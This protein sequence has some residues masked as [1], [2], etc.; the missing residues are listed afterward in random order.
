VKPLA[1]TDT[2][3]PTTARDAAWV[4]IGAALVASLMA[5]PVLRSPSTHVFGAEIVGRQHDPF[6]VMRAFTEPLRI[7]LYSQP[8]TD[9]PGALIARL[10]GP[11][12]AY[13]WL[14]LL[15]FPL[16]AAGAFL[17]ARHLDLSRL[18]AAFA[19]LAFA[20][21]PFHLAQAAYHPHIAQVQWMPLYLLVLWRA[22]D[23]ASPVRIAWLILGAAGVALANFYAGLMAAVLTPVAAATYWLTRVRGTPAAG[24]SLG[25]TAAALGLVAVAGVGYVWRIAPAAFADATLAFDRTQLFRY[26]AAWWS[27]IVPPVT[28]PWA[29]DFAK[30]IWSS[31][32]VREGLL[33]QQVTLGAGVVLLGAAGIGA[34]FLTRRRARAL[35]AVPTVAAVAVAAFLCSLPPEHAVLGMTVSSPSSWIHAI[36]PVFRSYAR[37]GSV[38]Q[39]MAVL[40]AGLGL[41]A[42]RR[43]GRSGPRLIGA[44]C[45]GLVMAEY[46][47]A[48]A[49]LSR[50]VLPTAAHRQLVELG[51]SARALD[52]VPPTAESLSVPWLTGGQIAVLGGAVGDCDEPHLPGKLSALGFT[53]TIVRGHSPA[54][55]SLVPIT[56]PA[57][58]I[59]TAG[60]S[61]FFPRERDAARTWRWMGGAAGW[62]VVNTTS[63]AVRATL[64]MELQAF[65]APRHMEILFDGRPHQV[66]LVD[67]ER[68]RYETPALTVSPG[69]HVLAFRTVEPA[70]VANAVT[71]NG[72]S[73]AL[74]IA[75]GTWAWALEGDR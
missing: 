21:S 53:H 65:H 37:F 20:F 45:I 7:G 49:G 10:A 23:R 35:W 16:A 4:A 66:V 46:A 69:P 6:T 1:P 55:G 15:T 17:L 29:G 9:V 68:R 34:W 64:Q 2:A 61:G 44:A 36:V 19:A 57:P 67:P 14:V 32:G 12:A 48:P 72:D 3:R 33:E 27:Y 31:A 71:G 5:W 56:A 59:Y 74:A 22:L 50:D 63:G 51:A 58:P 75:F 38:V 47:A 42:L 26:S 60:M 24:R 28:N 54:N 25:V 40:L 30:A 18:A 11:V 73:R 39:L 41:D 62:D 13:N 70:T 43:T 8:M 52:C